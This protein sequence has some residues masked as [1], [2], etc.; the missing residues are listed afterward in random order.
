M[1]FGTFSNDEIEVVV[2]AQDPG[3]S[4]GLKEITLYSD[5]VAVETKTVT[6]NF[7]VFNLNLENFSGNE[8]SASVKDVAGND[9]ASDGLTK[10]T[11]VKTNAFSNFVGLR[12]EKP[13]V[14]ITPLSKSVYREGEK[15]WYN[16]TVAFSVYTATDSAGIY[17]VEIKVNGKSVATDKLGKAVNANFF[18]SQMLS[19]TFTVDTDFN[20]LDGENNIEAIV[21]N[22]YGNVE[23]ARIKVFIDKTNPR[24]IGFNITAENNGMLSKILNFLSF[25]NFFNERV[26]VTVIADDRYGATSGIKTITLYMNNSSV[27]DAPKAAIP[28]SDGTYRAEFVLPQRLLSD[29]VSLNAVLSAVATD[30]VG[31]ITGKDKNNPNGVPITPDIVNSDFKNSRLIIETI[32]P[33]I[34]ISCPEPDF[35]AK[36]GEKWYSDDVVFKVTVK[37]LN[38]GIRSV[39]IKINGTDITRDKDGKAINAEFYNRE[40][41]E[42]VFL[43]STSQATRANNGSYLIEVTAVDN[44]GNSY[45]L[46][47]IVYKD[48]DIPAVT[49]FSFVPTTSDGIGNTSEFINFLEYGF[50]FKAEFNVVV[51][52]SDDKPSSGLDKISYRLVSYENGKKSEEKKGTQIIADGKAVISVPKGFKGQIYVE[53]F[54]NTKNKSK[55]VTPKGFVS[56]DAA[57]EISI[58]NNTPTNYNDAAGNKLYVTDMSFTVTISD[59]DSG[60]KEIGYSQSSEKESFERKSTL[61]ANKGYKVGDVLENG[62]VV[63]EMDQN[64]VTKVTKVFAFSSDNNDIFLTFDATDRSGNKKEDIRTERVTIDKTA[65]VINVDFRPD[66]SK[67]NYYYSG[68]RVAQITVVERNFDAGLIKT[69]IENKIGR[70]PTVSF[71]Q[72]SNTEHVAVIE[73]DEGDYTFDISGTDLG[74]HAAV[75]NFSG[76]NEKL[77][78]VDKT[79]PA[80]EENFATFANDAVSN[81]FNTDKTAVIKVTE[82]NFDP[83]LAGF[84][85]FRKD[86]GEEHNE[87]GFVDITSEI[88]STS[89][90]VSEGDVHTIS[91]TFNRD[92][93]YKMEIHP[94]DLAGNSAELRR[95]VV[96]EIDKTPP[97]VK[98]KNGVL[99]NENNTA[100]VE[101]YPYSRKDDP[102]PAVE[103]S[104]LNIDHIRYNLTVYI[105]DHTAKKLKPSLNWSRCIWMRIRTNPAESR[106]IFS[107]CPISH[108]T[109]FMHWN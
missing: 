47:D 49:D 80:I 21:T 39:R 81:S 45:S 32:N 17:S 10:P 71:S 61:I 52:V 31:N 60:I 79:K 87:E 1:S 9:S 89:R 20:A 19:E 27:N 13:T 86:P 94:E 56:D 92:A 36:N 35:V 7:A 95:T 43:V 2:T 11:D 4:S 97:V 37:D 44:A 46:S 91:F 74:N 107:L 50:Y 29:D 75:V 90:W 104:D 38:S 40:T 109:V 82:H 6:E 24:I 18:E 100:F 67:N 28:L 85:V 57:P 63:A 34:S 83:Q 84:K 96:F 76:G 41:H 53:A 70:V 3:I 106:E 103:F 48:T 54:D 25:G 15:E 101:I 78:Y 42:E 77:F 88:L 68:N 51:S 22:N 26:R 5:G 14:V 59:Y 58:T 72:K 12:D 65:P 8:I 102:V 108:G 99:V 33:A 23:T 69:T 66:E 16:D 62:W 30:N 98:A 105:P 64:L 73:F 93:V 55:E